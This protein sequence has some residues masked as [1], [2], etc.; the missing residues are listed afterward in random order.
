MS[1]SE[2]SRWLAFF[3]KLVAVVIKAKALPCEKLA[4]EVSLL[5]DAN[6]D[7]IAIGRNAHSHGKTL[8]AYAHRR[9]M[10][11][12]RRMVPAMERCRTHEQVRAVFTRLDRSI[13]G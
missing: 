2:V 3:D 1:A 11:G 7:A 5:I 10:A 12:V 4:A 8:P 6:R 13:K 9:M